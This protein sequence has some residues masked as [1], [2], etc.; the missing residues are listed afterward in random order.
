MRIL[1]SLKNTLYL[2]CGATLALIPALQSGLATADTPAPQP[3]APATAAAAPMPEDQ[4]SAQAL[5]LAVQRLS[6]TPEQTSRVKP[7][8]SAHVTRLRKL[9]ADYTGGGANVMPSFLEEFKSTREG[10]RAAVLPILTDRQQV[11]FDRL[12]QELDEAL[13]DQI[14]DYRVASLKDRLALTP[15]QQ[16]A[17]RP[18]LKNDFEKKRALLALHTAPTGGPQSG[19]WLS[20]QSRQV[21]AETEVRLATVLNPDQMKTY[22]A[23]LAV[24]VES[25][26]EKVAQP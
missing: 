22:R 6:L 13:R 19:R 26:G 21:Q 15:D 16:T 23:D 4:A 8:L 10:F 12:R 2:S 1:G 7:L 24:K 11:E 20:D 5:A 9:F 14:C 17:I 18:I 3:A 25:A